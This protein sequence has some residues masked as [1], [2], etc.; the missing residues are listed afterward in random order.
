MVMQYFVPKTTRSSALKEVNKRLLR[1]NKGLPKRM[2]YELKSLIKTPSVLK[3]G[4]PF[5]IAKLRKRKYHPIA[6]GISKKNLN[7]VKNDLKKQG[8]SG[9][10]TEKDGNYYNIYYKVN[11]RMEGTTKW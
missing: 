8:Y 2:Q 9:F 5:Y 1:D 7:R 3:G 4:R 6:I 11:G 10:K